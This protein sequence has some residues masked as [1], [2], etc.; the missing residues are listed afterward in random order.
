[1]A[2][3]TID[4]FRDPLYTRAEAA[5]FL[6]IPEASLGRWVKE[7]SLVTAIP[8]VHGYAT[9]PFVGLAEAYTLQALRRRGLP[10]QR[11]RPALDRLQTE[12]GIEHAL[13]SERLYTDGAEVLFRYR[14]ESG[15]DSVDDLVV[16]RKQQPVFVEAI[17]DYLH[18]IEY[19]GGY[20]QRFPLPGFDG[21]HVFVDPE[22]SFGQPVFRNGG[23]RVGDVLDLFRAGESLNVVA[24][25]FGLPSTELEAVVRASLTRAA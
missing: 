12:I 19:A 3:H 6:G 16:V 21:A 13:A 14:A 1:M 24:E 9:I 22:R 7:S 17:S 15:D 11:I 25:E 4:R 8:T 20:A 23:A 10:L 5:H 18:K 2:A